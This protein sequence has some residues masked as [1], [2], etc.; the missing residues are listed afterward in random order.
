MEGLTSLVQ[1]AEPYLDLLAT[2]E[3]ARVAVSLVDTGEAAPLVF[4]ERIEVVEGLD[5]PDLV[6]P[7]ESGVFGALIGGY[8]WQLYSPQTPFY[9]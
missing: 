3:E 8:L 1:D 9:A 2:G 6:L 4:R 5:S 7:M